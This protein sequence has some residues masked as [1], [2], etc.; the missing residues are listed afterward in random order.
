M[1]STLSRCRNLRR[2]RL[3]NGELHIPFHSPACKSTLRQLCLNSMTVAEPF[4]YNVPALLPNLTELFLF[5]CD[6][7][8]GNFRDMRV[9]STLRWARFSESN[10]GLFP[11]VVLR[12]A[13]MPHV[14]LEHCKE[15]KLIDGFCLSSLLSADIL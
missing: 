6:Y 13:F 15:L 9:I 8:S 14:F 4:I 2:L 1:F 12:L 5:D 3:D 11:D 10:S 7:L